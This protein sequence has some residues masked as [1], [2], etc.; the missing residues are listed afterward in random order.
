[1]V[2][3]GGE[4]RKIICLMLIAAMLTG[5]TGSFELTKKV[6]KFHRTI[7]NKWVDE[8]VFLV[9]CYVPVYVIAILADAIIF[10][11]I[12]FW[13]CEN[14]VKSCQGEKL[15]RVA[16]AGE[17]KAVMT[18]D[19]KTGDIK[20]DTFKGPLPLRSFVLAKDNEKVMIKDSE[21][22]VISSSSKNC[23][24]SVSL[25]DPK[26]KLARHFNPEAVEIAK[27]RHLGNVYAR[28]R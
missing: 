3:K 7:E 27:T 5:C 19:A 15:T 8:I 21:G 22:N 10:N 6:Y 20:V 26:G 12:E 14:P 1:M 23:D 16:M 13:T 2:K 18:Y 17:Y 25:Y 28:K 24:G 4:M 11:S 9:F